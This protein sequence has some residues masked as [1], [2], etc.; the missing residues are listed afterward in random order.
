MHEIHH[1]FTCKLQYEAKNCRRYFPYWIRNST[2]WNVVQGAFTQYWSMVSTSMSRCR[3]FEFHHLASFVRIFTTFTSFN[4]PNEPNTQER[5][6]RTV[7]TIIDQSP[8]ADKQVCA[9]VLKALD[10]K[11]KKPGVKG[12]THIRHRYILHFTRKP[13][14]WMQMKFAKYGYMRCRALWKRER[15]WVCQWIYRVLALDRWRGQVTG[16]LVPDCRT[17]DFSRTA[18]RG[19]RQT[20]FAPVQQR[21]CHTGADRTR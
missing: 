16:R 12:D 7:E 8:W 19:M 6:P 4:L 10:D 9:E 5:S 14:R 13:W 20:G 21:L 17:R 15:L 11:S 18:R 1:S 2:T 3:H